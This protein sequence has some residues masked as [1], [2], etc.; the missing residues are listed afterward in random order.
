MLEDAVA[1]GRRLRSVVQGFGIWQRCGAIEALVVRI[2][3]GGLVYY[4]YNILI[5]RNPQNPILI[6]KAPTLFRFLDFLAKHE[7]KA[8]KKVAQRVQTPAREKPW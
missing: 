3:Y 7:S 8:V 5:I 4:T 6:I 1:F 2:G